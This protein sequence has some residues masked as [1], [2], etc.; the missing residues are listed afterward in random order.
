MLPAACVTRAVL[1]PG[2]TA[3][4]PGW[5][6]G[7]LLAALIAVALVVTIALIVVVVDVR[8]RATVRRAGRRHR[9]DP[10]GEQPRATVGPTGELIELDEA[11]HRLMELR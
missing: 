2:P 7:V 9:T 10:P 3:P 8:V 5:L 6:T 1:L 4:L 11:R